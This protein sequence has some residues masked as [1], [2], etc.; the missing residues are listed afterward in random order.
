MHKRR[1]EMRA[2][3]PSG[4]PPAR[5]IGQKR[6]AQLAYKFADPRETTRAQARL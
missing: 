1:D 4:A 5:A 2:A 3:L 6:A